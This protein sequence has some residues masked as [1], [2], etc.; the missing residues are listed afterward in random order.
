MTQSLSC[1]GEILVKGRITESLE[2]ELSVVFP[3]NET[4][5]Y[6][7]GTVGLR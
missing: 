7:T 6:I 4:L 2:A 5:E 3:L 1:I